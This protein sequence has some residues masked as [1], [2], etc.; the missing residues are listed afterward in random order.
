VNVN[1]IL[2]LVVLRWEKNNEYFLS[3]LYSN[4]FSVYSYIALSFPIKLTHLE[5]LPSIIWKVISNSRIILK[6]CMSADTNHLHR[7]AVKVENLEVLEE[8]AAENS[9]IR[10][11]LP[12]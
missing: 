12:G 3:C 9:P 1:E 5:D 2:I 6:S 11:Y 7:F 10:D 8:F 4:P